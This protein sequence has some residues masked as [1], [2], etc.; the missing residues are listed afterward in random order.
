MM[1]INRRHDNNDALD[2][3]LASIDL[4]AWPDSPPAAPDEVRMDR[5]VYDIVTEKILEEMARGVVPWRKP[6]SQ[7]GFGKQRNAISGRDYRGI[8][9]I[10]LSTYS[11]HSDPRWLTFNQAQKKGGTVRRGERGSLVTFFKIGKRQPSEDERAEIAEA[12]GSRRTRL[13]K[14]YTETF[15]LRY[16]NVFNVEQCDGLKLPALPG[17][18][19]PEFEAIAAA[20]AICAGYLGGP[21]IRY[22]G[23]DRAFY[24]PSEDAIHLPPR[25]AFESAQGFYETTFH[26]LGHSTG[27]KNRLGRH[28]DDNPD[29]QPVVFGSPVYSREELVAEFCSAFLMADAGLDSDLP[30]TATYIAGWAQKFREDP[31]VLVVAASRGQAA[32]D[33]IIGRT[34]EAPAEQGGESAVS[35]AGRRAHNIRASQT[36]TTVPQPKRAGAPSVEPA[37]ATEMSRDGVTA[38]F[39]WG[40]GFAAALALVGMILRRRP[41]RGGGASNMA[42]QSIDTRRRRGIGL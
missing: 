3:V 40:L 38:G 9:Q 28:R 34:D 41:S 35:A 14:R 11:P 33:H 24:R 5:Q 6:W 31:R 17:G 8:N 21:P 39:T 4:A 26:E 25:N 15:I 19:R 12:S 16:Y 1:G 7:P 22:D 10:L 32:A 27:H 29:D 42:Q 30:N 13:I 37:L 23:G 2:R 20:E 18:D 36:P